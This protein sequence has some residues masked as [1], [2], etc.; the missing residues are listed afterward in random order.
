MYIHLRNLIVL[1]L[2]GWYTSTQG[3]LSSWSFFWMMY[4]HLRNLIIIF[5][6]LDDVHPLK[7]FY[8]LNLSFGWCLCFLGYVHSLR[9]RRM[10][11]IHGALSNTFIWLK[12]KD[13]AYSWVKIVAH[14]TSLDVPHSKGE[15]ACSRPDPLDGS[16][17]NGN[18][19]RLYTVLPRL[20]L[21]CLVSGLLLQ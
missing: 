20:A 11:R 10:I 14:N 6:L 4:I 18:S 8:R 15:V 1:F 13:N 9:N 16:F 5:F 21:V 17:L 3:I 19:G 7:E 12:S 2:L